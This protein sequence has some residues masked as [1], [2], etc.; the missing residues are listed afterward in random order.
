MKRCYE[1]CFQLSTATAI[2]L[3]LLLIGS[4]VSV[5]ADP[6]VLLLELGGAKRQ[7]STF[8]SAS[9]LSTRHPKSMRSAK[10]RPVARIWLAAVAASMKCDDAGPMLTPMGGKCEDR[11]RIVCYRGRDVRPPGLGPKCE[12]RAAVPGRSIL[13]QAVA[14]QLDP[15]T[16][17]RA[18]SRPI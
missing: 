17:F 13:A 14:E 6:P 10:L 18:R 16:G 5:R 7:F 8:R 3:V 2:V 12:R 9:R 15:W 1:M 11:D 4:S